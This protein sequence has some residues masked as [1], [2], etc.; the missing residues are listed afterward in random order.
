HDIMITGPITLAVAFHSPRSFVRRA[1]LELHGPGADEISP[2]AGYI[3]SLSPR[4]AKSGARRRYLHLCGWRCVSYAPVHFDS[5]ARFLRGTNGSPYTNRKESRFFG[6]QRGAG[7]GRFANGGGI[8][9]YDCQPTQLSRWI[10]VYKSHGTC[11]RS[12]HLGLYAAR[13]RS[14]ATPLL[15]DCGSLWHW[16]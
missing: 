12:K 5:G 7:F 6:P 2:R 3:A 11:F 13:S 16:L 9:S 10:Q 8:F 14:H 1:L 4:R 15:G